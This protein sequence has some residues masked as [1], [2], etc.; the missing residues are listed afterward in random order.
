MLFGITGGIGSGKSTIAQELL[1]MGYPVFDTDKCAQQLMNSNPC[2]RSQIE[3][4]FGSDIYQNE[5]LD[6]IQV[7]K[8]VFNNSELLNQL[9]QIVHPA[10]RFELSEWAKKKN[11]CFVESAIL[12]ESGIDIMCKATIAITAPENLRIERACIRDGKSSAQIRQRMKNQMTEEERNNKAD[13]VIYND[14]TRQIPF[15]AEHIINF[16]KQFSGKDTSSA[17]AKPI[18]SKDK[19]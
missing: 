19:R 9:N 16:C 6:R 18:P 3:L 2:I 17:A 15:L 8:Q 13:L 12:F 10:V 4:L 14:G 5:K 11:I 7:A 1:K